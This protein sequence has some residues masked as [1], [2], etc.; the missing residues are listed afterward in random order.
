MRE[1]EKSE[2]EKRVLE[3]FPRLPDRQ[4]SLKIFPQIFHILPLFLSRENRTCLEADPELEKELPEQLDVVV[5][6]LVVADQT[7]D[8]EV[9]VDAVDVEDNPLLT[10]LEFNLVSI[11]IRL[12]SISEIP[13]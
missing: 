10:H 12:F 7:P 1:R 6:I 4:I 2:N 8:E 11:K 3:N 9:S 5:I 13:K